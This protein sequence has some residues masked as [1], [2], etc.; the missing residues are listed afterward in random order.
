MSLHPKSDFRVSRSNLKWQVRQWCMST[1]HRNSLW[2]KHWFPGVSGNKGKI[3]NQIFSLFCI[4]ERTR[5][6][7]WSRGWRA[8]FWNTHTSQ[9]TATILAMLWL[10][11]PSTLSTAARVTS[12]FPGPEPLH[13]AAESSLQSVISKSKPF[14]LNGVITDSGHWKHGSQTIE[15]RPQIFQGKYP[16]VEHI[17]WTVQDFLWVREEASICVR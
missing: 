17:C 5:D 1:W 3:K 13:S 15:W 10:G 6:G 14:T 16:C 4:S 11:M 12:R 2:P 7:K 8:R 9:S